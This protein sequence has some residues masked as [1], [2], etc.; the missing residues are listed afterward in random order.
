MAILTGVKWYL[1]IVLICFSLIIIDVEHLFMCELA[2]CMSSLENSRD[3][4]WCGPFLRTL[5]NSS[6]YCF[7]FIF[8]CF[9][10]EACGI[11]SPQPGIKPTSL[12][13]EGK[14]LNHWTTRE[15]SE[16]WTRH[17]WPCVCLSPI[18]SH[19]FQMPVWREGRSQ[20]LESGWGSIPDSS[21]HLAQA[22]EIYSTQKM[23]VIIMHITCKP[24]HGFIHSLSYAAFACFRYTPSWYF[25]S[26]SLLVTDPWLALPSSDNN[27]NYSFNVQRSMVKRC[28]V[29]R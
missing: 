13:L 17:E 1:I 28:R 8:W 18:P 22:R 21:T 3:F 14:N 26:V 25:I 20:A 23:S 7:C 12:A 4:F 15:I 11:S 24:I 5:L 29:A 6:Q 27:M 16:P 2:I 9:G 10:G 19:T